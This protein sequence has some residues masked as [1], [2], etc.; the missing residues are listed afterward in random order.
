MNPH[1]TIYRP[2]DLLKIENPP[3]P[4]DPDL[5]LATGQLY[6]QGDAYTAM[7]GNRVMGC[8]GLVKKW[9]GTAIV[10]T[11]FDKELPKKFPV[12][13]HRETAR[14]LRLAVD[15]NQPIWRLESD[16]AVD[17]RTSRQWLES[18]GFVNEGVMR[19]YGYDGRDHWRYAWVDGYGE[20]GKPKRTLGQRLRKVA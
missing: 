7:W 17:N 3:E 5:L 10:W 13:M 12:W 16:V 19:K 6:K 2:E 20:I 1:L 18:L 14:N 4:L 8:A 9:Q 11:W 15:M